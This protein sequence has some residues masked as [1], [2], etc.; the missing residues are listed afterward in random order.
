MDTTRIIL[1][2]DDAMFSQDAIVWTLLVTRDADDKVIERYNREGIVDDEE[3]LQNVLTFVGDDA[4][5]IESA[6]VS[7]HLTR[8]PRRSLNLDGM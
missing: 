4:E 5:K 2:T 3:M 7:Y 1:T 8:R 6:H